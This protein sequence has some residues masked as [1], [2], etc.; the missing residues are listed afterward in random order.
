MLC[1]ISFTQEANTL[2]VEGNQLYQTKK[3]NEAIEKF[4]QVEKQQLQSG[5]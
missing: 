4:H 3:Y 1:Q 2:F 5:N